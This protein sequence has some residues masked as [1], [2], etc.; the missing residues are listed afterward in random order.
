M[1]KIL[2]GLLLLTSLSANAEDCEQAGNMD[3]IRQCLFDQS[4]A[5]VEKSYK[6]LIKTLGKNSE[7]IE[8]IK[9]SQEDWSKFMESTCNYVAASYKGPGYSDDARTNCMA[10]FIDARAKIL[11][12]YIKEAQ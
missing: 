5:P 1:K 4:Y 11:K 9:K 7:A 12:K 3:M 8:A 2:F 10:D 6:E